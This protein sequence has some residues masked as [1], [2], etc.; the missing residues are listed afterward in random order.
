[1]QRKLTAADI[2]SHGDALRARIEGDGGTVTEAAA[3][4]GLST[5]AAQKAHWLAGCFD[6]P[7]RR[8]L[9]RRVLR[10]LSPMHLEVVASCK[11]DAKE[12]LLRSAAGKGL[13]ARELKKLA[14]STTSPSTDETVDALRHSTR[15][16]EHYVAFDDRSLTTLLDGPNGAEI[17]GAAS[18]GQLLAD[19]LATVSD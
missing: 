3:R 18:A 5:A 17:R 7:L 12:H 14:S 6:A 1:M 16:M 9:G 11:R 13:T 10:A 4:E 8:K 15:A 2:L 19:R